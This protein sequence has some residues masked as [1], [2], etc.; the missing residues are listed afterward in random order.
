M[1]FYFGLKMR[2]R[3]FGGQLI[4]NKKKVWFTENDTKEGMLMLK[5]EIL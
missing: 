1:E 4:E 5:R 3:S 2:Y